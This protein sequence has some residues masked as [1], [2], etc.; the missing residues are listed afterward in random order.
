M[1]RHKLYFN[2][3]HCNALYHL[4]RTEAGPTAIDS[5]VTCLT[6]RG[7]IAAREGKF[8]LQ[9]FSCAARVAPRLA[10]ARKFPASKNGFAPSAFSG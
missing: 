3:P 8:R 1:A 9:Y 2:C 6:C 5:W 4:I 10:G 7:P